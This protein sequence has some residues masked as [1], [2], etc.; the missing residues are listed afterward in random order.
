MGCW[1]FFSA[2]ARGSSDIPHRRALYRKA[3]KKIVAD[4]PWIPLFHQLEPFLHKAYVKGAVMNGR[5][6]DAIR[7]KKVWLDKAGD[8]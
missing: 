5:G 7:M 8:E 3:Q 1:T 2:E 6:A 4:A